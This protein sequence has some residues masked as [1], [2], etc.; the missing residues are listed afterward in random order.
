VLISEATRQFF[1]KYR[2]V[3]AAKTR[4]ILNGANLDKF[5]S[6]SAHPGSV[7]PRVRFGIAAR[8]VQ[9]KDHFTLLRA[10]ALVVAEIPQAELHI[11]GDGSLR[12]RLESFTQELKLADRVTFL[13]ALPDTPQFLSQLDVFVLSSLNEGLPLVLL[14]A[15]AAGLPV[16][17]TC[18]GGV[19]EAA[20]DGQNAYLSA[21]GD[22]NGLAEAM[23]RMARAPDLAQMGAL[24][25]QI[26]KD[27]FRIEQTWQ[28]YYK[29]FLSL[30]ARA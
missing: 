23:I 28:E 10:F 15:M 24:G 6:A 20:I 2:G 21:P 22:S 9:E 1:I 3:P 13:G 5:L 14:E 12:G 17:S 11:A 4:V 18:A 8:M 30:G 29:L 16:V 25:R 7:L 26:V 27:R 19:E